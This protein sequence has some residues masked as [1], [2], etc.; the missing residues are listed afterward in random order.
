MRRSAILLPILLLAS[1][2]GRVSCP[3]KTTADGFEICLGNGWEEVSKENLRAEGVPE[4]TIA[5]FQL[6][7]ER[8]G[9]RDN[10]VVS[11]EPLAAKASASAYAEANVRTVSATPEY[12]LIEK[13]EVGIDGAETLLHIFTARPVPD[14]PARRFYQLSLTEGNTGYVFTGTLPLS[15]DETVEKELID[16]VLS[17]SLNGK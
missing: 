6:T 17:V 1:C 7:D 14:L 13:R 2:S 10:V 4:E 11:R 12:S 9:Q 5:A 15:V 16:M 3:E 8:G